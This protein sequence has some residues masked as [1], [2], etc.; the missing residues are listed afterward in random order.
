MINYIAIGA[1]LALLVQTTLAR[2]SIRAS[3]GYLI[4]MLFAWP[5]AGALM[6]SAFIWGLV[7][8]KLASRRG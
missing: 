1:L 7:S 2:R 3:E 8:R 6:L 4:L 5:V